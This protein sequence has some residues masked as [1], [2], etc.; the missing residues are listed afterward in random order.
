MLFCHK[1]WRVH[2]GLAFWI[3]IL[4]LTGIVGFLVTVA[5]LDEK[6]AFT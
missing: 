1:G 6:L 3:R 4:Y 5:V 2:D